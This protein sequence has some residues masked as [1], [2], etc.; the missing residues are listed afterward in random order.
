MVSRSRRLNWLA[1][2]PPLGLC[3]VEVRVVTVITIVTIVT[4]VT[5]IATICVVGDNNNRVIHAILLW[6]L[7]LGNNTRLVIHEGTTASIDT[8]C[9]GGIVKS[10]S[11]SSDRSILTLPALNT[12]H[13]CS[14]VDYFTL[15]GVIPSSVWIVFVVHDAV[16]FGEVPMVILETTT[17]AV[18]TIVLAEFGSGI[19]VGTVNTF[20]F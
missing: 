3:A 8:D 16:V 17:A 7:F 9:D 11:N 20:L 6:A 4:I 19:V 12:R 1:S 10:L 2:V 14:I 18:V 15:T 13:G 5:I